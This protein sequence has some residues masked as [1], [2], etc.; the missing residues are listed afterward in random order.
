MELAEYVLLLRWLQYVTLPI[1]PGRKE[2]YC[3]NG[4]KFVII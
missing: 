4:Q 1:K 3:N 2:I